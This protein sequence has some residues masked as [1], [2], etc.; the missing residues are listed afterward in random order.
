[1]APFDGWVVSWTCVCRC[2]CVCCCVCCCCCRC[3]NCYCRDDHCMRPTISL[4]Q[5][6]NHD[7]QILPPTRPSLVLQALPP[8]PRS[9]KPGTRRTGWPARRP[10]ERPPPPYMFDGAALLLF[11]RRL[12]ANRQPGAVEAVRA[13]LPA[14]RKPSPLLA[15]WLTHPAIRAGTARLQPRLGRAAFFSCLPWFFGPWSR[16]LQTTTFATPQT[17]HAVAKHAF[18]FPGRG[19]P[20]ERLCLPRCGLPAPVCWRGHGSVRERES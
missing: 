18:I 10:L 2:C 13:T 20:R 17:K 12:T 7:R 3:C 16:S 9:R 8:L 15:R 14:S 5:P 11:S 4:L 19:P 6:R 1:M